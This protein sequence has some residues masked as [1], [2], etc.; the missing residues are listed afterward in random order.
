[1]PAQPLIV[2]VTVI[3]PLI[4]SL[5][6]FTAVKDGIFPDPE[7]ASPMAVLLFVQLKLTPAGVP[8]RTFVG[9]IV[10][11]FTVVSK[12]EFTVA[13]GITVTSRLAPAVAHWPA[14][15]VNVYE[16]EFWLLITEGLHVPA[17][18]FRDVAGRRGAV[19]PEQRFVA[20]PKLN[21]GATI[22]FTVTV[23]VVEPRHW[24][25]TGVGV[26]VYTPE[27]VLSTTAGLHVPAIPLSDVFGN[28]GT[29]PPVQMESVVPKAK[30]GIV[31]AFTVTLNVVEVA[32]CP[33]L[34]VNV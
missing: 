34:G 8:V 17:I 28:T 22:G 14:V 16:P 13:I 3:V 2:G 12:P 33:A 29:V 26:N 6:L 15:V 31:F 24:P 10:P 25:A 11:S 7:P 32:H 9:M 21:V 30:V 27:V 1:V 20:E 23:K 19:V 5:P 4:T 18:P